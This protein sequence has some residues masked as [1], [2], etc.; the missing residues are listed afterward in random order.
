[1]GRDYPEMRSEMDRD[2][3]VDEA[4]TH[5]EPEEL[6]DEDLSEEATR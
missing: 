6:E 2:I 3:A 4:E 1:M 5:A